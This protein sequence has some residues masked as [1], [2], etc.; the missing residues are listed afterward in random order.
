MTMKMNNMIQ[1]LVLETTEVDFFKSMD[2]KLKDG[3]R[4]IAG[5]TYIKSLLTSLSS[6]TGEILNDIDHIF[7]VAIRSDKDYFLFSKNISTFVK[8][9]N[10][11]L[12]TPGNVLVTGSLSIDLVYLNNYLKSTRVRQTYYCCCLY[13]E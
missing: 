12:A 7:T 3:Y 4:V 6:V 5:A 11:Y 10:T 2:E 8:E 9:V 13:K 1:F